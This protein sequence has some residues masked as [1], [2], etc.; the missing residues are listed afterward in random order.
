[1]RRVVMRS[2]VSADGIL[3]LTVPVG[4]E[5]AHKEVQVTVE[6]VNR[7]QPAPL[8]PLE[9]GPPR[10]NSCPCSVFVRSRANDPTSKRIN[11]RYRH[12]RA[13]PTRRSRPRRACSDLG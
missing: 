11:R 13:H 3:H 10:R 9:P 1:M 5:E 12:I 7:Q 2:T 6:P 4:P 8:H